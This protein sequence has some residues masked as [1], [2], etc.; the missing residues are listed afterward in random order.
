MRKLPTDKRRFWVLCLWVLCL[1]A[2]LS[3]LVWFIW[4]SPQMGIP[5]SITD[6]KVIAELLNANRDNALK[7]IQTVA[8][9]GFIGTAYF[10]WRNLQLTEAKNVT[11]RFSKAVEMLADDKLEVRLGGIYSLERIARDSK[12]DHPVVMEVLTAF[13]RTKSPWKEENQEP[14]SQDI[15]S[16]LTVIGRRT[17]T[18][19]E[20]TIDL[21]YANLSRA[22]LV[23]ANFNGAN[24]YG[25]NFNGANLIDASLIGAT[26]FGADLNGADLSSAHLTRAYLINAQLSS[27]QLICS[28]LSPL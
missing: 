9:L 27:A 23:N 6:E 17:P 25:A 18:E 7:V 28:D 20:Q 21:R 16:A 15:Q 4:K 5:T 12:A 10:A 2:V 19:N 1:I 14:I 11:D 24:F 26:L 13:V 22:S 8:G 3:F